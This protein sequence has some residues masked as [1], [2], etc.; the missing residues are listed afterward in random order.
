MSYLCVHVAD[1][2]ISN[3]L[4]LIPLDRV[5]LFA[6]RTHLDRF[7]ATVI[8]RPKEPTT[9]TK[10]LGLIEYLFSYFRKLQHLEAKLLTYLHYLQ[11][12]L[13]QTLPHLSV[14]I[15]AVGSHLS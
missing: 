7:G 3:E 15:G 14:R 1:S 9:V 4:Q 12:L 5:I 2:V 6:A 11:M 10:R 8:A 13:A